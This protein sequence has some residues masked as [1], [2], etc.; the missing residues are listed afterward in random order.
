MA[1]TDDG[2]IA[3]GATLVD[4]AIDTGAYSYYVTY[5][6]PSDPAAETRPTSRVGPT[7][8][9][10]NGRRIRI[11][12]SGIPIPP[13]LNYTE[14]KIYRNTSGNSSDFRLVDTVPAVGQAGYLDSY[15]DSKTSAD[16]A[17]TEEL[18]LDGP[19]ANSG[20]KLVD[21][22]IRDGDLYPTPFVPGT[23][24]FIG[25]KNGVKLTEK[26]LE[27]TSETT[28]QELLEFTGDA[29]GLDDQPND[30]AFPPPTAN[31]DIILGKIIVTSNMGEQNAV[32]IPLT[33]FSLTPENQTIASSI[34]LN[35]NA[36]QKAVGPGTS[37][38]FIAYD[39]LG[40]PINVRITTVLESRDSTSTSYRW[41][42]TSADNQ[43][44]GGNVSTVVGNGVLV[45]DGNGDLD[46]DN[47]TQRISI[48]RNDTASVSPLEVIL[49]FS[50]VKA[51]GEVDAQQN[52][53]STLNVT[54]QDGFSARCVD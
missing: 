31:I 38:E 29:L 53:I 48:A 18:N 36:S 13:D 44:G 40:L 45:F 4:D 10:D 27:I 8:I 25:E 33:A 2:S 14:M 1:Y 42:A 50:S 15:I 20:T 52:P 54:N 11:D 26:E 16:I 6:N 30:T 32:D 28:V 24:A 47:S 41:Y 23:L 17:A 34:A 35:F 43:I 21:L 3:T 46:D 22:V 39:S 7:S 19:P 5:N 12:L 49:D 37:S 9:T 51:L